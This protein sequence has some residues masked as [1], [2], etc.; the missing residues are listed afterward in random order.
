[1]FDIRKYSAKRIVVFGTGLHGVKCIYFLQSKGV[2][3]AYCLNNDCRDEEFCGYPVYEPRTE[4]MRDAFI[5]VATSKAVYLDISMQ[6]AEKGL[7]EFGDYIY[8]EWMYKKIVLLHGNCHISIVAELLCSSASFCH[9]YSLYPNAPICEHVMYEGWENVL[10]N[11]D[12]WI[13]QDIRT[14]NPYGYYLSDEYMKKYVR[15]DII[16][17]VIPNL[18]GLGKFYFPQTDW[19]ESNKR[20]GVIANGQDRNGMFP[21][22]DMII[23]NCVKQGMGTEA[24]IEFCKGGGVKEQEIKDNFKVFIKKILEREKGWDIKISDFILKNYKKMKLFYDAGHPTNDIMVHISKNVLFKLDIDEDI[25]TLRCMDAHEVPV[26]PIVKKVLNLEWEDT[27]IR[28]SN[29]A[30]KVSDKMGFEEYITQ[31][32]WWCHKY[33]VM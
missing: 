27:L 5:I 13:H 21:H 10:S 16:E 24:I 32:L 25:F 31:Y 14:D 12:V 15:D 22:I 8:Y 26:Y 7:L 19:N 9:S 4:N 17:I 11:C 1:M 28:K 30:K 2:K 3:I 33:R 6:L 20:N 29:C 18:F 23:D